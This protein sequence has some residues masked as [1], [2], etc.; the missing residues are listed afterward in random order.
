MTHFLAEY[1][2]F[3]AKAFTVALAIGGCLL[4]IIGRIA[5]LSSRER[6][7]GRDRITVRKLNQKFRAL[8]LALQRET[9]PNA[10]YKL[11]VKKN[12]AAEKAAAKAERRKHL[13]VLDF[14]G[15]LRASANEALRDEITAVLTV[16][17]ATDEV[18]VRVESGGGM[19]HAYGLAASQLQRIRDRGVPLTVVVDKIAASGG[20]M[21]ACVADKVLAAPFAVLGSIGVVAQVP[22]FHRLLKQKDIDVELL[23]AGEY[24]RTVTMFGETTEKG[25]AKFQAELEETHQLFKDFVQRHRA[26][27][28]IARVATGEH[29]YG[30]QAIDLGLVDALSTSDDYLLTASET[31]DLFE[32]HCTPHRPL[33]KRFA[34]FASAT[35]GE[36]WQTVRQRAHDEQAL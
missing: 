10:A 14:H 20:Y 17:T 11:A 21:M 15:D 36:L 34:M 31:A 19:V 22:N 3:A 16:A 2:L 8:A 29:W 35:A 27:I 4:L 12:R 23:T 28:D 32:I 25:R 30:T 18:L 9:L 6:G 7:P 33:S 1:G 13:Y 24:K 5:A 26:G